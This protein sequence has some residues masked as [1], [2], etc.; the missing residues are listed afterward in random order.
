MNVA[1][2]FPGQ[3]SQK[4]GMGKC[5][6]EGYSCARELVEMA[7]DL[8]K[9]CFKKM[10]FTTDLQ[11][12]SLTKNAQ[13]AIFVAS[14][15][16]YRVL[17]L[18]FPNLHVLATSGLSLGEYSAL[19][20]SEIIAFDDCLSLVVQRGEAM[21]KACDQTQGSMRAVIGLT[22]SEVMDCT[23][24][25]ANINHPKQIVI[26]GTN[27][28]LDIA[29]EKLLKMG[30]ARVVQLKVAGAFHSNLMQS[31]SDHLAP[32]IDKVLLHPSA[33][34]LIQN[35]TASIAHDIQGIK[36]ALNYG[37]HKMV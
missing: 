34:P 4:P 19:V 8:T 28:E 12:L 21:H 14:L 33:C 11:E 26:A 32:I 36:T 35:T 20:A 10:L 22:E 18:E 15:L 3:G 17:R 30:A 6:Y 24:L 7:S 31:A 37:Y 16:Q 13:P 1:L 27:N 5:F 23:G 29:E 2:I 25:I 9:I